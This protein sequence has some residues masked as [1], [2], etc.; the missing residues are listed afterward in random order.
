LRVFSTMSASYS[1]RKL[2]PLLFSYIR[3]SLRRLRPISIGNYPLFLR[4]KSTGKSSGEKVRGKKYGEKNTEEN[5][6]KIWK[7]WK[8]GKSNSDKI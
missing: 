3:C 4:E 2:P 1:H 8:K 7:I 5:S 6:E